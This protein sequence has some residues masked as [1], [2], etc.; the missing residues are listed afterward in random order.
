MK[1]AGG[2]MHARIYREQLLGW[3]A[4]V[5]FYLIKEPLLCGADT[6]P[7]ESTAPVHTRRGQHRNKKY[8]PASGG[9]AE[10]I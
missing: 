9:R 4:G 5:L 3:S 8:R 1:K 7:R 10:K 6:P 2:H